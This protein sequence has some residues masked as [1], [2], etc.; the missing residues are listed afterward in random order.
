MTEEEIKKVEQGGG[1]I[2]SISGEPQE[3]PPTSNEKTQE[4]SK[5]DKSTKEGNQNK[6]KDESTKKDTDS[7]TNPEILNH[8]QKLLYQKGTLYGKKR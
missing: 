3:D 1:Y 5:K 4:T 2:D 6:S 7:T 8:H